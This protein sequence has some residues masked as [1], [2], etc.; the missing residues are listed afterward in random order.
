M[1][2]TALINFWC[3]VLNVLWQISKAKA[4]FVDIKNIP[5]CFLARELYQME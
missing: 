4:L 1:D 2:Q 5:M 3:F